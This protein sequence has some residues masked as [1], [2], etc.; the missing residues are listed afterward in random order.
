[1]A[2][3]ERNA[4][5]SL[6]SSLYRLLQIKKI[7]AI[8]VDEIVGG[9]RVARSTFYRNFS[10]KYEL[11]QWSYERIVVMT[12]STTPADLTVADTALATFEMYRRHRQFFRNGLDSNDRNSLHR[13]IFEAN[14]EYWMNLI[15]MVGLDPK[16]DGNP[17]IV[18][19]YVEGTIARLVEW[20]ETGMRE[21]P[22]V[23]AAEVVG[24]IPMRFAP[25]L[26][27]TNTAL[28]RFM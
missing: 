6:F 27:L 2:V 13:A 7:D 20:V 10:D 17:Q 11:L 18:K 16:A 12:F 21:E 19:I 9:A 4:K 25:C 8:G 3:Y 15:A 26:E 5:E 23:L 22:A 14:C 24:A 28:E 1:M